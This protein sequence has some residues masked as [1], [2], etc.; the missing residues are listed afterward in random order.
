ML[1]TKFRAR[2]TITLSPASSPSFIFTSYRNETGWTS[3]GYV[4]LLGWVLTSI[5]TGQDVAAHLAEEAKY[6]TKSVPMGVFW[7]T[8]FSYLIGWIVMLCIMAVS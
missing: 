7:G 2:L 1:H 6:P 5:A 8:A 4:Y 3:K